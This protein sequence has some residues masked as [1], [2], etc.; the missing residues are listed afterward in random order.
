MEIFIFKGHLNRLQIL[1]IGSYDFIIWV[2]GAWVL[3]RHILCCELLQ[4]WNFQMAITQSFLKW[5][6]MIKSVDIENCLASS[7]MQK[8]LQKNWEDFFK[9][10]WKLAIFNNWKKIFLNID[11]F[12]RIFKKSSQFFFWNIFWTREAILNVYWI[13]HKFWL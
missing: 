3:P 12:Q 1:N 8:Y 11:D 6:F 9:N 13:Y 5:K 4:S 2:Y 7:K 10:L